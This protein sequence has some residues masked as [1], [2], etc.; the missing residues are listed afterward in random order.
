MNKSLILAWR[1][2]NCNWQKFYHGPVGMRIVNNSNPKLY[3]KDV[4][5]DRA[6]DVSTCYS[7]T[8]GLHCDIDTKLDSNILVSKKL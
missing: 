4:S 3:L 1:F 5:D 7:E 8:S 6:K 2:V